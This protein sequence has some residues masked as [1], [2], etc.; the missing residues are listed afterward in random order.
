MDNKKKD[1]L[2]NNALMA[3]QSLTI[4]ELVKSMMQSKT[5][6]IMILVGLVLVVSFIAF[7]MKM[8]G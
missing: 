2:K 1:E 3:A 8:A 6:T 7:L 5:L 4:V